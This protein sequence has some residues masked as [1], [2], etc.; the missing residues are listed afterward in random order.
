MVKILTFSI[1]QLFDLTEGES[2]LIL[3][4]LFGVISVVFVLLGKKLNLPYKTI[5]LLMIFLV[6]SLAFV[7]SMSIRN[8]WFG[9]L[10]SE[11]VTGSTI[12]FVKNWLNENPFSL[13]FLQLENPNSIEFS[14]IY[15]RV[16]YFS[17]PI[18]AILPIYLINLVNSS[19]PTTEVVMGF[20][21]IN[22]WLIA[23]V[24]SI[25]AYFIISKMIKNTFTY[26]FSCLPG[27]IYIFLPGNLYYHQNVY[28]ADQAVLLPFVLFVCL[29]IFLKYINNHPRVEKAIRLFQFFI[30]FYGALCDWLFFFVGFTILLKR[31]IFHEFGSDFKTIL[32]NVLIFLSPLILAISTLLIQ[33]LLSNGFAQLI[34]LFLFR[35]GISDEGAVYTKNFFQ[36]FWLGH[37]PFMYGKLSS[38]I[39]LASIFLLVIFTIIFISKKNKDLENSQRNM[40]LFEF[41][42][43]FL[44]P[45]ILQLY[46][47]KNHSAIHSFSA[48]KLSL[49][50]ATLPFFAIP[51]LIIVNIRKLKNNK[52]ISA[53]VILLITIIN[54]Q[55]LINVLPIYQ[56]TFST[57]PRE[58]YEI[59][60]FVSENTSYADVVFS[61]NYEIPVLPPQQ[62][63]ISMKR[64]YQVDTIQEIITQVQDIEEDYVVNI[65][66]DTES[67]DVTEASIQNLDKL[68]SHSDKQIEDENV[69]LY[70][71]SKEKFL[72]FLENNP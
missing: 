67:F 59:E 60:K 72:D 71:I 37:V 15:E 46:F 56:E 39:I 29:E 43:L 49:V 17:Y 8:D 58:E 6:I 44:I 21:L 63:A 34:S 7:I 12:K 70:K 9:T 3:I 51:G 11:W 25:T 31:L 30:A 24:F 61:P 52:I 41:S 33:V 13:Y 23:L 35:T 50:L 68:L 40:M 42:Y 64:V 32:K 45:I 28:Y 22:Q 36:Q 27:V 4:L 10:S 53:I 65:L 26:L 2:I 5:D 47:L 18:G 20:N 38:Y 55:F 69:I 62:L 48:Q 19:I 1:Q 54:F 57:Y 66:I 14:N 16:F